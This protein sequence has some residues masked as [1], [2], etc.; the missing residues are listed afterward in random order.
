ML[1]IK[2]WV[3]VYD[4][5]LDCKNWLCNIGYL[6]VMVSLEVLFGCFSFESVVVMDGW[7]VV[8]N[9]EWFEGLGGN[10]SNSNEG[11]LFWGMVNSYDWLCGNWW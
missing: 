3:L 8:F 9:N 10:G 1:V 5:V 7:Y 4:R 11:S 2:V 6:I